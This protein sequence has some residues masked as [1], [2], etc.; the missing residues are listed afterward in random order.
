M[1]LA[2]L[3]VPAA[4]SVLLLQ[5]CSNDRTT[6]TSTEVAPT[7]DATTTKADATTSSTQAS[8]STTASDKKKSAIANPEAFLSNI[9]A[10]AKKGQL[11]NVPFTVGQTTFSDIKDQWG[12]PNLSFLNTANFVQYRVKKSEHIAYGFGIG[13]GHILYDL[14]TFVADDGKTP[15]S[16]ISFKQIEQLFGKPESVVYKG[17][18]RTWTYTAGL[19]QLQF[20]G[21][22][23]KHMLHH[24]SVYSAAYD[25]SKQ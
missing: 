5:A 22:R 16:S 10:T 15:L 6:S 11:P 2:K 14:R 7:E 1:K 12:E 4:V 23:Q 17:P 24:I 25:D 3:I 19:Y 18:D 9:F 8:N 20:T 13:R 21:N